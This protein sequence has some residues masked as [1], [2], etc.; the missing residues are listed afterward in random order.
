[1][2]YTYIRVIGKILKNGILWNAAI[3]II[4]YNGRPKIT[5][6]LLL[7]GIIKIPSETCKSGISR[8]QKRKFR[9]RQLFILA[10]ILVCFF[11]VCLSGFIFFYYSFFCLRQE[12]LID[13]FRVHGFFCSILWLKKQT[14]LYKTFYRGIFSFSCFFKKLKKWTLQR[15]SKHETDSVERETSFN[16]PEIFKF[17]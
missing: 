4:R 15:T 7:W 8:H 13:R 14:H 9:F 10:I 1:M 16:T 3:S 11:F 12:Y 2:Y 17:K 6:T 5:Y